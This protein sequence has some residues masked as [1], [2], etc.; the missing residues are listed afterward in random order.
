MDIKEEVDIV[1]EEEAEADGIIMNK[2][3]QITGKV[4]ETRPIGKVTTTQMFNV[5]IVTSMVILSVI[6]GTKRSIKPMQ[7]KN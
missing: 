2:E 1:V 6:V 4:N 7:V 3:T 5:V